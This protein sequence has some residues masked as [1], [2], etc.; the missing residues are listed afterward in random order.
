MSKM[1]EMIPSDAEAHEKAQ[2]KLDRA[3]FLSDA[4]RRN[5]RG[6]DKAAHRGVPLDI[7]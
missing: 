5:V 3:W 2:T 1:I 6:S 4:C 7:T